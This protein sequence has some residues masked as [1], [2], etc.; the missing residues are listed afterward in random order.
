MAKNVIKFLVKVKKVFLTFGVDG[1]FL[2]S[3]CFF[4]YLYT[5]L[6]VES[7]FD[8][9]ERLNNCLKKKLCSGFVRMNEVERCPL[10]AHTYLSFIY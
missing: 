8:W 9:K 7:I 10:V 4:F 3:E 2:T 6:V 1:H 5:K